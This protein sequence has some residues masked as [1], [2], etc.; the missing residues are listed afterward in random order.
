[1]NLE[2]LLRD[3]ASSLDVH[4]TDRQIERSFLVMNELLKWN[5]KINLTSITDRAQVVVKHFLDSLAVVPHIPEHATILDIGSGGGFPVL[6]VAIARP[7]VTAVSV[8]SVEKKIFFQRQACRV[9]GVDNVTPVHARGETLV[10]RYPAH[11]D[12]VVSRAFSDIPL[13]LSMAIPVLRAGGMAIAMKGA[14]G[15]EE[16]VEA[17]RYLPEGVTLQEFHEF[18][19]PAAGGS[20]AILKYI[21]HS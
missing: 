16:A 21:K 8:D 13:F 11:F 18:E 10:G 3:G 7:D 20:R 12:I 5:R 14:R 15:K 2:D 6:P 17:E 4:L 19:L 9:A 1:M